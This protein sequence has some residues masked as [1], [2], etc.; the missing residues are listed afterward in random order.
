MRI[1]DVIQRTGPYFEKQGVESPRLTIE[2]LLAHLLK[3]RR[4]DLYLEFERELD[5]ASLEKLR[6]MV[7]RR[8]VGEPLQYITGEAEFCGLKFAVDRRVLIPRPETELLVETTSS[9]LTT[10]HS[11]LTIIDLCTGSGCVAVAL[12][13]RVEAAELYAT[14]VSAEALAVAEENAKRHH[15]EKKV[16]FFCGDLLETVPDSLAADAIVSNPPYIASGDLARLPKEVR[17]FEPVHALTA[18][19]DGLNFYRRIVGSARRFLLPTGFLCLEL[20]DG[21]SSAVSR[22]CAENGWTVDQVVKD[23]Q[24]TE[25]VMVARPK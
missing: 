5:E 22:L 1:L 2:L 12:A 4:L 11:P 17:E 10:H 18:G 14:D 19:E 6:E 25:R 20:G 24:G 15:V 13:A 16:R 21:Q 7:R 9:R 3:K 23:L 8:A